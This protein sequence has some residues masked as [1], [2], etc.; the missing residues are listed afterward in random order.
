MDTIL[1]VQQQLVLE[2]IA[3][4][5]LSKHFYFGGG[6]ALSH[7]YLQ[8]RYSEN[9][10]FFSKE[11]FDPQSITVSLK[12][13]KPRLGFDSYDYQSSFNRNLDFLRFKD[14]YVLKIEFTYYPFQQVESQTQIQEWMDAVKF[15]GRYLEKF[16]YLKLIW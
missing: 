7:Y 3:N 16:H 2:L 4:T 12:R 1:T 13:L 6:T 10:D 11:E 14:G 5:D 8:H 15:D 9:L